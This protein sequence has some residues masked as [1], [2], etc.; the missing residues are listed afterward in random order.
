MKRELSER[1]ISRIDLL[2]KQDFE[3]APELA[4]TLDELLRLNVYD[5]SVL[6]TARTPRVLLRCIDY[7]THC[8]EI[9]L[10]EAF[11]DPTDS[12]CADRY[13][14]LAAVNVLQVFEKLRM[15]RTE[16]PRVLRIH[17]ARDFHVFRTCR[18]GCG[19][20]SEIEQRSLRRR[21]LTTCLRAICSCILGVGKRDI[22]PFSHRLKQ[23][24]GTPDSQL[25]CEILADLVNSASKADY[26]RIKD[27]QEALSALTKHEH[28]SSLRQE[29]T[30][31][32]QF[33]RFMSERLAKLDESRNDL[34]LSD[35]L[36][37]G[38][39]ELEL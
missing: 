10:L 28:D 20:L 21:E 23:L 38:P 30:I 3:F 37:A 24:S 1:S 26:D 22:A 32:Y 11:Q 36:V 33:S 8:W 27:T 25:H 18:T 19:D 13:L 31:L 6:A 17:W 35:V 29:W 5:L 12:Q 9:Y 34:R 4:A 15:Y 7:N 16:L 2:L 39:R 14:H